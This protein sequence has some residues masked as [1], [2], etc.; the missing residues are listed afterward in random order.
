MPKAK[1]IVAETPEALAG[2]LGLSA[3]DAREWQFQH[4]L[5][6]RLR[7]AVKREGITHASLADRTGTSRARVTGILNGNL[8]HVSSDLLIRLLTAL[9]YRVHVRLSKTAE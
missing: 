6:V 7:A 5:L 9:G 4:E 2:A 1:R 8:E 3:S